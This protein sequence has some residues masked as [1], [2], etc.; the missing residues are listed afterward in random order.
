MPI[1]EYKCEQTGIIYEVSQSIKDE[2]LTKCANPNCGCKG[3]ANTSRIISKNIGVVFNCGGFYET[4]YVRK[5]NSTKNT[6]EK[7][8]PPTSC[9]CNECPH[10]K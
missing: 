7:V 10:A 9:G 1:Y 6:S 4:D 8:S 3:M 5:N 2:S